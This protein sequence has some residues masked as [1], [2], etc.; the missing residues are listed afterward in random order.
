MVLQTKFQIFILKKKKS[1]SPK[2]FS[3]FGPNPV[4]TQ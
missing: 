2:Y 3:T 1:F 4:Q